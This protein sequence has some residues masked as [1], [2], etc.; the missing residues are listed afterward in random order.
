ME[1]VSI[2]YEKISR[3]IIA[4]DGKT[5]RRTKGTSKNQKPI[6]VVSAWAK[7]QTGPWTAKS[8]RKIQLNYS[9]SRIT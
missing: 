7:K 9:Y 6:H 1:W 8:E 2:L 4:L 3:E 5:A